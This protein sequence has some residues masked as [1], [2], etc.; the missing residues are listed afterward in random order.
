MSILRYDGEGL[1]VLV[2]LKG[3]PYDRNALFAMLESDPDVVVTGVEHP[4]AADYLD[5]GRAAPYDVLLFY[6]MP[7]VDL[8]SGYP[9]RQIDPPGRVR[10]GFEGLLEAG[11]GLV[12]LHHAIAAWPSWE[13]Y[14]DAV[15]GRFLY[16][17]GEVRG[18][19]MP[20]SGYRHEV[21]HRLS[22]VDPDHP[23]TQGLSEGFEL[24]DEVY[25]C[26]IFEEDVTPL[27]R[28]DHVFEDAGFFSSAEALRGRLHS[29]RGWAHP[30]G[31]ALAAW[32]RTIGASTTVTITC[33]DG[34]Q[35]FGNPGL[36]RLLMNAIH[37]TAGD[38]AARRSGGS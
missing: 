6:D 22:P 36:R 32:T 11:K 1:Q 16:R 38:V 21:T 3:H 24:C 9:P 29:R 8:G 20:D 13:A 30:P 31:S 27:F 35:A 17:P 7:G 28:S 2:L 18:V 34:P 26:P 14:G 15:G 25:L 23:V 10:R 4:A 37:F 12:F 19:A 5:A 33:G